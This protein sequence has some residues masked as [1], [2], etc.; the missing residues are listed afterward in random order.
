MAKAKDLYSNKGYGQVTESAA[1]TLTFSEIR[2]NVSI[3]EKVAWI[4]HRIEWYVSQAMYSLLMDA[5]DHILM[6]LTASDSIAT[7]GLNVPAVIDLMDTI[8]IQATG[9]GFNDYNL[10]FIRDFTT[11]P[12]GGLII[13][14]RPL[15]LAVQGVS[16]GSAASVEARFYFTQKTLSAD[17]YMELIDFYRIVQ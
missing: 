1:G 9:V 17:E 8:R 16:L 6:A 13:A 10:P 5:S 14:P 7:L 15:F 3:F 12:G 11:L 4:L 2:T